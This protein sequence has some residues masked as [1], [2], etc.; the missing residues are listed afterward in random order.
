M[1]LRP[2]ITLI[3]HFSNLTDPR[4]D[5]TK[6]HKLIDIVVIAVCSVICGADG[7]VG[8][9]TYGLAK[10]QWLKQFLELP[11][12]IPSHDTFS[13]V[14]ARLEPE[15]FQTCFLHWIK[16]ISQLIPGEV[17]SIDGKTLRHSYDRESK[18]KAIHMISAWAN[19]QKLVL[20]QRKVDEK[21]NEITAIPELI[22]VLEL[23]GCIV[24]ID[25]MGTQKNIAQLIIDKGADYCLALKG[26]QGNIH[27][28]VEQL[29]ESCRAQKWQN[30]DHSFFQTTE[31]GHG[32]IETR[33]YWTMG[34]VEFLLDAD[35]WAGLKSIGMV[36]SQRTIDGETT[37]ET[38]YYL[39]SF[40]SNAEVFA[41][42][43]RSHWGIEN[44]LH[45]VLDVS[46]AEDDCR[47]RKDNSPENLALL[48]HLAL[49]LLSQEKTAKV[50]V[51]N[52]RLK[53]A[54]DE[55]YLA[56]VLRI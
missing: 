20:G 40:S 31:K 28:D 7:W 17:I 1:K 36:E 42:A 55:Q 45:W 51:K 19:T 56:K 37:W 3:D 26:N 35:K 27:E 44:S 21:S 16:S 53:A 41:D 33:R 46:F 24:T 15:E 29:F 5:R 22:K 14:F 2:K 34:E 50:G 4:I 25:A 39:N 12:G 18:K 23:S 54:W 38:R 11:N 47:I 48:R 49:N 9:E 52:K 8:M 13:R 43:V 6:E 30:I 32:R 10:Y